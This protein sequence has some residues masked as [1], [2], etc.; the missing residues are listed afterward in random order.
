MV[1]EIKIEQITCVREQF[2]VNTLFSE[3]FLTTL[4]S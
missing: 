4:A 2:S 3:L 1:L